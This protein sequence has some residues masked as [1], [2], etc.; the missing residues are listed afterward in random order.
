MSDSQAIRSCFQRLDCPVQVTV[1]QARCN[2]EDEFDE[3]GEGQADL[4]QWRGR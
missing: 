3:E 4:V 2:L 1:E